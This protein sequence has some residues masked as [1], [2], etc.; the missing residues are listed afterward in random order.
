MNMKS[1]AALLL[2]I[3]LISFYSFSEAAP[4][5]PMTRIQEILRT[6][7]G[8]KPHLASRGKKFYRE[9]PAWSRYYESFE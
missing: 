8:D 3:C 1:F 4:N 2:V 9:P 5:H 6:L 7:N